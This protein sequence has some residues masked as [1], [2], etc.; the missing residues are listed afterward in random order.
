MPANAPTPD[1]GALV[2]VGLDWR[3][4]GAEQLAELTLPREQ[5]LLRLT[6]LKQQHA[7]REVAYLATCN[8]VEIL[9]MGE[10]T[11]A[12]K[13]ADATE[14]ELR[15]AVAT[16]LRQPFAAK[17][18]VVRRGAGALEHLFRVTAGLESAQ[19]GE[20][21]I[22]G[23]VQQALCDGRAMGLLGGELE[24]L[25][26]AAVRAARTVHHRTGLSR[27]HWSL[28]EIAVDAVLRR[29]GRDG[30]PGPVVLVGVSAM[31]TKCGRRL[32]RQGVALV[33]ANRSPER[34]AALANEL[35]AIGSAEVATVPLAELGAS[36]V[37]PVALVCATAAPEAVLYREHLEILCAAAVE[38]AEGHA[39][40]LVVDL[41]VPGD[42]CP[43]DARRLG[44]ERITM[45]DVIA[46]ADR[47]RH[48]RAAELDAAEAVLGELLDQEQRQ[49]A[50]RRL[51]PLLS[52]L[53]ARYRDTVDD[54]LDQILETL[55]SDSTQLT[56]EQAQRIERHRE[57]VAR[58][59]AHIPTVGLRALAA[60]SHDVALR[61]FLEAAGLDKQAPPR[62]RRSR[63]SG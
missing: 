34:A 27:G 41:A 20:R 16:A 37:R 3:A 7:W 42:V 35:R 10:S 57:T 39:T 15:R 30:A 51:A 6:E 31:T 54:A 22:L 50:E 9:L 19:P 12:S 55:Q 53:Q 38:G 4:G 29:I 62:R 60:A 13:P 11:D 48:L 45:D 49:A 5:R 21:E 24:R 52:E 59:L 61:L 36:D 14:A 63:T 58:R 23:Q 25:L 17:R 28:A 46:Q 40:P 56:V 32:A 18:L 8:R 43:D 44:L 1:L 2:S 26:E 47:T 33:I